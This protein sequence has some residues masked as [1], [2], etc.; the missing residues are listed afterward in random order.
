MKF[1]W[2]AIVILSIGLAVIW[3]VFFSKEEIN[4]NENAQTTTVPDKDLDIVVLET[5]FGPIKIKVD[6]QAAPKTSENFKKLASEK[7]YDGLT[8]HRVIPDFV[9]QGGD[10]KADGTGGPGYNLPAEI[11]LLHKKGSVAMARLPDQINPQRESSGSQFYIALEDLLMLDGAYTVFG[12][13][14]S[15]MEIVEKIAQVKTG[16]NDKPLESVIINK[17]YLE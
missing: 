12:E 7:F 15:G 4:K 17:A 5:S 2:T 3:G 13:V 8:F 10:P 9:V 16:E 14:V 11:S 1:L 6:I